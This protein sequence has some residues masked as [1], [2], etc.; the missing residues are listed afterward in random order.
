LPTLFMVFIYTVVFSRLMNT[1]LP[2]VDHQYAYSIYLCGGLMT[3]NLLLELVQRGKGVFLEHANLIKKANFPKFI[4]F[5]PVLAVALLNSFI[6]IVLVLVFMVASG[7]PL[8]A[9]VLSLVPVLAITAFLGLVVGAL[10]ATLNVFFRD[11]GQL[12]DVFFQALFWAT[13]VVYPVTILSERMRN[14]LSWNP[15]FSLIETSQNALLGVSGAFGQLGYPLA[16]AACV[17]V[18]F[19]AL[20]KRSY[21][22]LLDQI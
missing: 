11:I 10:L 16:V 17:L 18:L 3:W 21:A 13:P 4:L 19:V 12:T 2:G 9:S 8:D 5:M 15:V 14:V 7:Y 1:R 6:L 20:Y 22:D